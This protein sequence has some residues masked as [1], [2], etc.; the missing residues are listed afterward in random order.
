MKN[1]ILAWLLTVAMTIGS[2][3]P[4][5]ASEAFSDGSA[6]SETF[7]MQQ[8]TEES[9]EEEAELF[10]SGEEETFTG[11]DSELLSVNA[12]VGE[13]TEITS[14]EIAGGT[15][16][17]REEWLYGFLE[18]DLGTKSLTFNVKVG[19]NRIAE[20]IKVDQVFEYDGDDYVIYDQYVCPENF[21]SWDWKVGRYEIEFEL[22][23][24]KR[25][26]TGFVKLNVESMPKNIVTE[27]KLPG[28]FSTQFP[29][30]EEGKEYSSGDYNPDYLVRDEK[31]YVFR[32][33][34][35]IT[36]IYDVSE[37]LRNSKWMQIMTDN[38]KYDHFYQE[39]VYLE[40]GNDLELPPTNYNLSKCFTFT[41]KE[42]GTYTIDFGVLSQVCYL[43]E[44]NKLYK[45]DGGSRCEF[46]GKA[47]HPMFLMLLR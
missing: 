3:S 10:S 9:T 2:V 42:D 40:E 45:P 16:H 19:E 27:V 25:T 44:E 6:G 36:G 17:L 1:K 12:A 21:D 20:G 38:G 29:V 24:R 14:V 26:E 23:K 35:K 5:F 15:E 34:P 22:C 8:Q 31:F 37:L 28:E 32:F 7:E 43:D 4:A 39:T 11:T 47:G 13:A 30:L 18:G 41:P 33:V 46:T